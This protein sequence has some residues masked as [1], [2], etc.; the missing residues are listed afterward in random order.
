MINATRGIESANHGFYPNIMCD[1]RWYASWRGQVGAREKSLWGGRNLIGFVSAAKAVNNQL[2][3]LDSTRVKWVATPMLNRALRV[4]QAFE[5]HNY[6]IQLILKIVV[7]FCTGATLH[8]QIARLEKALEGEKGY[9][10]ALI[11]GAKNIL[12]AEDGLAAYKL[13]AEQYP[14]PVWPKAL[15]YQQP[16]NGILYHFQQAIS[17]EAR[18]LVTLLSEGKS[19]EDQEVLKLSDSC[20]ELACLAHRLM[21]KYEVSWLKEKIQP[22]YYSQTKAELLINQNLYFWVVLMRFDALYM[23]LRG[24]ALTNPQGEWKSTALKNGEELQKF[25]TEG[26]LQNSWREQYNAIMGL[27]DEEIGLEAFRKADGRYL[28]GKDDTRDWPEGVLDAFEARK[29]AYREAREEMNKNKGKLTN[30]TQQKRNEADRKWEEVDNQCSH[31]QQ[32][33][34]SRV[35]TSKDCKD[36]A[37]RLISGIQ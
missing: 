30:T 31:L 3:T 18:N 11:E 2:A 15:C 10:E 29:L 28:H 32:F 5:K 12:G 9:K 20:M 24:G 14:I 13:S 37:R 6:L 34:L 16:L 33:L 4:Q 26:T 35:A 23:F 7:W 27:V 8:G 36:N 17:A 22:G 1:D 21:V 19:W 25:F